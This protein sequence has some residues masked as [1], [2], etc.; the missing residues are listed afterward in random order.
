MIF[1]IGFFTYADNF[2]SNCLIKYI[3]IYKIIIKIDHLLCYEF[4]LGEAEQ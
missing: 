2:V 4:K 3:I 1:P